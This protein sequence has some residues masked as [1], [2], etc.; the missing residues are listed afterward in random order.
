MNDPFYPHYAQ[1]RVCTHKE[2]GHTRST[3]THSLALCFRPSLLHGRL[4]PHPYEGV[5]RP[6]MLRSELQCIESPTIGFPQ[7]LHQ[8]AGFLLNTVLNVPL[9]HAQIPQGHEGEA[10]DLLPSL[11]TAEKDSY[12][13]GNRNWQGGPRQGGGS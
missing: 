10:P 3:D 1:S 5:D 2:H 7:L 8:A 13:E 11:S 9:P 12:K 6:K 4:T